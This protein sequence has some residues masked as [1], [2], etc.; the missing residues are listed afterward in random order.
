[1][2]RMGVT[3]RVPDFCLEEEAEG[4]ALVRRELGSEEKAGLTGGSPP[5]N[6]CF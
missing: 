2:R 1:M 5:K 3:S 4:G 6:K